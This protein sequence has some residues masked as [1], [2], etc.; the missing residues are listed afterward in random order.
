MKK[1]RKG[2]TIVEL[3]IV[4]AVIGILTAVLVPTFTSLIN[5]ANMTADASTAKTLNTY[6]AADEVNGQ[7]A[8]MT[9]VVEVLDEHGYRLEKLKLRDNANTLLWDEVHNRFA[10]V[11]GSEVVYQEGELTNKAYKLWKIVDND[12]DVELDNQEYSMYLT[13]DVTVNEITAKYGVDVGK[14]IVGTINYETNEEQVVVIRSNNGALNINAPHATVHHYDVLDKLVVDAVD[15]NSY[16]EHGRVRV[17]MQVNAGHVVVEPKAYVNELIIPTAAASTTK[18]DIKTTGIVNTA[19]VDSAVATIKVEAGAEVQQVVGETENIS[20]A[21]A[22]A[23]TENV[24]TKTLVYNTHVDVDGNEP[25]KL[26][27]KE[28][29][30]A[31][32]EYI[33]LAEDITLGKW[34]ADDNC[35]VSVVAD[36]TIDGAGHT[37]TT[38]AGRGIWVDNSNVTLNVKNLKIVGNKLERAFQINGGMTGVKYYLDNCEATA[39][40]YTFNVCS[41]ADGADIRI[42]DSKLTGWGAIN[43][44]SYSY[45]VYISNSELNGVNDKTYN[46]AG[47]NDFGTVI[48]EGDTTG[49]TDT[50]S[51]LIDVKIVNTKIT[52]AQTTGNHQWLI[53]FNQ[54]SAANTVSLEGCTLV[55]TDGDAD[56]LVL[57]N[58]N[59]NKLYIDGTL[60]ESA[61]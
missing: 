46:A 57:G 35:A 15:Q 34:S 1:L 21:G 23:A 55:Y 33:V 48:L 16:Y 36:L 3:V 52:G 32:A 20:G 26:T 45:S 27:M 51:S 11:R 44:W 18:V 61:E 53:L 28:A 2:F 17:S 37:I 24:I 39:T 54:P 30:E 38:T 13:A 8:T 12:E 59:G 10:V 5:K 4:I 7:P 60:V 6:L 25:A 22:A 31:G 49:Q 14:S 56:Y 41:N 19:V 50:H 29:I 47:W 9:D 43:L 42:T 58:Q 40:Y